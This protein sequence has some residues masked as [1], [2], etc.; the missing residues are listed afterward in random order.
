MYGN[1]FASLGLLL[2]RVS[3]VNL[4]LVFG[5]YLVEFGEE[6]RDAL[7][8]PYCFLNVF[9][10]FYKEIV[11]CLRGGDGCLYR[12]EELTNIRSSIILNNINNMSHS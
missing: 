4:K 2:T 10:S 11:D 7:E 5:I 12:F 3:M 6:F 1:R 9:N 8:I